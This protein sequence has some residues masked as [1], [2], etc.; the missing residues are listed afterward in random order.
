MHFADLNEEVQSGKKCLCLF[1]NI[2]LLPLMYF[3]NPWSDY[4]SCQESLGYFL[5]AE[6]RSAG[7]YE[8]QGCLSLHKDIM[9]IRLKYHL[10]PSLFSNEPSTAIN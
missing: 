10:S 4:S 7:V 6:H 1:Q 3:Y 5:S 2:F 8:E 9:F